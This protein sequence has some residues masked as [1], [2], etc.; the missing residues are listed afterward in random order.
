MCAGYDLSIGLSVVS[1]QQRRDS[2][3][4]PLKHSSVTEHFDKTLLCVVLHNYRITEGPLLS[5][6]MVVHQSLIGV[7]NRSYLKN[8]ITESVGAVCNLYCLS[9]NSNTFMK[10]EQLKHDVFL[11]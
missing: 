5:V 7:F 10:R 9:L 4:L 6:R 3:I 8:L 1:K 11:Q 2:H